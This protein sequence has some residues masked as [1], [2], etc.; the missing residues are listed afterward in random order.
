MIT[1][2]A[3][4]VGKSGARKFYRKIFSQVKFPSYKPFYYYR[5]YRKIQQAKSMS[6]E[7]YSLLLVICQYIFSG[8]G[9]PAIV[10][11]P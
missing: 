4:M 9:N 1:S 6:K 5:L 8:C 11:T 7:I 10:Q 3:L 2:D